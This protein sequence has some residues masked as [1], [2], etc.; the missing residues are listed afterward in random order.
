MN[1]LIN[2]IKLIMSAELLSTNYEYNTWGEEYPDHRNYGVDKP[3]D[4]SS[5]P[6]NES[7]KPLF[8]KEFKKDSMKSISGNIGYCLNETKGGI[9][10]FP[11]PKL[12]FNAFNLTPLKKVKVVII[13]QDPYH[14][15]NTVK[16]GDEEKLVPQAMGLS[17]SVPE[18]IAIPSSL[19][20]IYKNLKKYGHIEERPT[21][22]NLEKWA[23]QGCLM[24]NATLTVQAK[25][26]NSHQKYWTPFTDEVIK[27]ISK[28]RKNVIFVLWGKF[29]LDKM[30]LIDTEKHH[31][32]ISS[33]PSG[34]SC[35]NKLRQYSA[36]VDQDHFGLIN[37]YLKERKK[38][39]IKWTP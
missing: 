9:K 14:G 28:K 26:P 19:D 27:Y 34:Y 13:G 33:H 25:C 29:A 22:G 31:V 39:Q 12:V 21:H 1:I 24:L 11:Y 2:I 7:W 8:E 17:F 20:S 5:L 15:S 35:N 6:Y 4:L 18:G 32:I 36:F 37:E 3:I 16:I 23:K 30:S 38:K 10:I